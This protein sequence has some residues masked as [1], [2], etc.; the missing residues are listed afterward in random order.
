MRYERRI[1]IFFLLAV[2]RCAC[3]GQTEEGILA[4]VLTDSSGRA[5]AGAE[6]RVQGTPPA[7]VRSTRTGANGRFRFRLPY[8][9]YR[10]TNGSAS[11]WSEQTVYV[12]PAGQ[13]SADLRDTQQHRHLSPDPKMPEFSGLDALLL[14]LEPTAVTEPLNLTG[15]GT[16]A[17]PLLSLRGFSWTSTLLLAMSKV[18]SDICRK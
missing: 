12:P 13:V 11:S 16:A 14:A 18:T 4:G 7:F 10:L 17:R 8:G 15:T 1:L 6:V 3:W 9:V 5:I 2:F